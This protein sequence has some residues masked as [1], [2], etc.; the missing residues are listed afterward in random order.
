M[1]M[2]TTA[3]LGLQQMSENS[4]KGLVASILAFD[5]Y[6]EGDQ[7]PGWHNACAGYSSIFQKFIFIFIP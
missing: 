2:V 7:M 1:C 5:G 3:E 4:A 6:W